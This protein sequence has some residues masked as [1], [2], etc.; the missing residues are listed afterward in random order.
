MSLFGE[1]LQFY[2]KQ[3]SMTQEQLAEKLE[4]SRQTVSKW[5]AG[6]SYA[7]MEKI[8]LI[9]DIFCCDM[10]TLMRKSAGEVFVEDNKRHRDHMAKSRVRICTGIIILITALAFYQ[11]LESLSIGSEAVWNTLF[12][13]AAIAAVLIFVLQGLENENYCRKYPYIQDFYPL[14]EK[15]EFERKFPSRITVGIGFILIGLL[16]GISG[17]SLPVSPEVTTDIYNGVFFLF[18]A[19][20]I[21][22]LV[23]TGLKKSEYDVEEYNRNNRKR[24][25]ENGDKYKEK[26]AKADKWCGCIMIIAVILFLTAGFIFKLWSI[27]WITI[28]IGGLICAI[29]SLFTNQD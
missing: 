22:V 13:G 2:R 29:I 26:E 21:G 14:E 16:F 20:G 9:C 7:E 12:L 27:C 15:E 3:H 11:I 25:P 4:V 5:E 8:L 18:A 24:C 10:D 19:A 28:P 6:V 1:N 23:N 17:D